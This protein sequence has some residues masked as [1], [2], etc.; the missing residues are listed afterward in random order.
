[1]SQPNLITLNHWYRADITKLLDQLG[2]KEGREFAW[3]WIEQDEGYC[4]MAMLFETPQLATLA[5]L[6]LAEYL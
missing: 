4:G 1:M 2:W 5:R 6:K 3:Y